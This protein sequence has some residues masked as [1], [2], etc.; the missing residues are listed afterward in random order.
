MHRRILV[1][2]AA[3]ALVLQL[4]GSLAAQ[5][6]FTLTS[7]KFGNGEQ[8][9]NAYT[10]KAGYSSAMSPPL[11]WTGAPAGTQSFVLI[12]RNP[13][14]AASADNQTLWLLYDIPATTGMLNSMRN[15][16]TTFP[17]GKIGKNLMLTVGYYPPCA[18]THG[19]PFVLYAL[20][21]K[22]G[23]PTGQNTSQIKKA[24]EGH[25]LATTPEL[26]GLAGS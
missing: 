5:D 11:A 20:D 19:Y 13:N 14:V 23:L 12:M 4:A 18:T 7:P 21:V 16:D 6:A 10:C 24:M 22:L 15:E 17:N 2:T 25:V 9:P 26:I 3:A 1:A 8:I